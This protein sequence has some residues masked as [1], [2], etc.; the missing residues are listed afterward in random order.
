MTQQLTIIVNR[1]K[2]AIHLLGKC[3]SYCYNHS[4]Y[5]LVFFPVISIL[6]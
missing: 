1:L 5:L 6:V 3:Y 4:A 2:R